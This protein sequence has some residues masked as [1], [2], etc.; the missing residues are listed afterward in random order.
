LHSAPKV[1]NA[2]CSLVLLQGFLRARARKLFT[3]GILEWKGEEGDKD[4]RIETRVRSIGRFREHGIR[5]APINNAIFL[6]TISSARNA[7]TILW[8]EREGEQPG[9]TGVGGDFQ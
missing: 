6:I 5:H 3:K 1:G 8:K 4:A 2:I 7:P 9:R